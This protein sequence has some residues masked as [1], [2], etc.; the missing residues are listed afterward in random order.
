MVIVNETDKVIVFNNLDE[1]LNKLFEWEL[2]PKTHKE[3]ILKGN[4]EL[5]EF[6]YYFIGNKKYSKCDIVG[7]IPYPKNNGETAVVLVNTILCKIMPLYLKD[8]QLPSFE[9]EII[10]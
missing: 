1:K 3:K 5:K 7:Y 8:M 10:E 4:M 6:K 2:I 9:Y